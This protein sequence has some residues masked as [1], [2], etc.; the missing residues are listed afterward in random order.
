[1][2]TR[3]AQHGLERKGVHNVAGFKG[4]AVY[5]RELKVKACMMYFEEGKTTLEICAALK[6]RNRAQ[7]QFWF[8]QCRE[9]GYEMVGKN[10]GRPKTRKSTE[11]EYRIKRLEMENKLLRDFLRQFEGE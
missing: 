9:G 4:M 2:N 7:P 8:K 3:T 10:R 5:P 6:I 11:I 1:M